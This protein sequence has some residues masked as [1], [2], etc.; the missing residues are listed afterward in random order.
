M[1]PQHDGL[2][3]SL[4]KKAVRETL[5]DEDTDE[6]FFGGGYE[7]D[8]VKDGLKKLWIVIEQGKKY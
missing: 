2:L 6:G 8:P 3:A 5:R 1:L 4:F 7:E